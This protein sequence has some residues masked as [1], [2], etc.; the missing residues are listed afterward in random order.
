MDFKIRQSRRR[1]GRSGDRAYTETS[2]IAAVLVFPALHFVHAE[3]ANLERLHDY[4][5][6]SEK[7]MGKR[8]DPTKEPAKKTNDPSRHPKCERPGAEWQPH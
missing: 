6:L 8:D 2:K 7:G 5:R 3:L 1:S 4:S